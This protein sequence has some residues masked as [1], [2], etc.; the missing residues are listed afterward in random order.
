MYDYL[1]DFI[2]K[3]IYIRLLPTETNNII[4]LLSRVGSSWTILIT[5]HPIR[6]YQENI[7][8]LFMSTINFITVIIFT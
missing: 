4:N 8:D 7:H 1:G 5:G 6:L 2:P 3:L